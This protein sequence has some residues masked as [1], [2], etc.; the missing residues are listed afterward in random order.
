MLRGRD[1]ELAALAA[2]HRNTNPTASPL[3]QVTAA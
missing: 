2:R 3:D 1:A